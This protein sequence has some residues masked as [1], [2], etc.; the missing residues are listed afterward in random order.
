MLPNWGGRVDIG[1]GAAGLRWHQIVEPWRAGGSS[2][3]TVVGFACDE[4]VRRNQGRIGSAE[5]PAALRGMLSNLP[6]DRGFALQDAGDVFCVGEELESAHREYSD[7]VAAIVA[8]RRLSIGL[9]GGH[10]IAWAT[11]LGLAQ[12]GV[13]GTS[14]RLGILNFDAHFD[15]RADAR[16]TS[17]TSFLRAIEHAKAGGI[18]LSYN[19]LGISE[20]SNTQAHFER[21][22]DLGV[23]WTTDD[24]MG[25]AA[26]GLAMWLDT[27]DS[28]YVTICL[29]V[30]PASVAPG[31]SAPAGR[32][33][34]IEIL[35]PLV[36]LAATRKL[37]AVDVA[38]L[39][40]RLDI[41]NR[42]ARVAA[43][44]LWRMVRSH[45]ADQS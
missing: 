26:S 9:G 21:A 25:Q 19:V 15:L 12:S 16:A 20:S 31:V 6:A 3:A 37:I 23:Y 32:G 4:G 5:G 28:L 45:G 22:R 7:K 13:L 34:S 18:D 42:T 38:E 1:D 35:E 39:C 30:L 10:D 14:G 36:A 43:R 2:A 40:P 29:D 41:D 8:D 27:L 33:V 11:Y 17:G 24:A 44:L